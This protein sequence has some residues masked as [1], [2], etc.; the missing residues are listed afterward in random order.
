MR[1]YLLTRESDVLF[2]T[3]LENNTMFQ[4]LFNYLK[5]KASVITYWDGNKKTLKPR[6]GSGS[7][8]LTEALLLSPDIG[9]NKITVLKL[10]PKSTYCG[11][12]VFACF[13]ETSGGNCGSF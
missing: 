2:F 5:T 3:E 8:E 7:I 6:K 1:F 10:G 11:A 9:F 13:K 12:R 4:K